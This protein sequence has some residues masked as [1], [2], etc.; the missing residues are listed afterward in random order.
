MAPR[1]E[2]REQRLQAAVEEFR[3]FIA[4]RT[5]KVAPTVRVGVGFPSAGIRGGAL[6]EC[7][8]P[9]ATSDGIHEIIVKIDRN[10][11][12]EQQQD[13]LSTLLHEVCHATAGIPAGH[14]A[15]FKA[16]A[17][18]VDLEGKMTATVPSE[19]LRSA[20]D[21]WVQYGALG[22][23]PM[24]TFKP[25]L[26]MDEPGHSGGHRGPSHSGPGTQTTRMLKAWC[27]NNVTVSAED[28]RSGCGYTVRL[29]KKWADMA[30][31]VCPNPECERAGVTLDR[32]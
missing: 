22:A 8:T 28:E 7:W 25:P 31:P 29:T 9:A 23:Y 19:D 21:G 14:G 4:E 13:I 16:V 1:F 15:D 26:G 20:L 3:E 18:S 5:G 27:P 32:D 12:T 17:T 6:A 11:S 10:T 24:G 30:L 2:T